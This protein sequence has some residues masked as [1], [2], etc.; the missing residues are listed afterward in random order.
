VS[1]FHASIRYL[2]HRPS[3]VGNFTFRWTNYGNQHCH[4]NSRN[5]SHVMEP[6][7]SLPYSQKPTTEPYPEPDESSPQQQEIAL[8][9]EWQN[10][11]QSKRGILSRPQQVSVMGFPLKANGQADLFASA[12]RCFCWYFAWLTPRSWRWKRQVPLKRRTLSELHD[13]TNQTTILFYLFIYGWKLSPV[14]N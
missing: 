10:S 13:V 2:E 4:I 5:T 12:C 6:S 11:G 14:L 7:G 3:A 1:I 8:C 9:T